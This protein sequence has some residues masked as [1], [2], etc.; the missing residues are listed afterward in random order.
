M[1]TAWEQMAGESSYGQQPLASCFG[2]LRGKVY[3]SF[4]SGRVR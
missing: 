1:R 2:R 3:A 4:G